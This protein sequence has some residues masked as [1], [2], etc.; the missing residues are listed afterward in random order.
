VTDFAEQAKESFTRSREH[1]SDLDNQICALAWAS[2]CKQN[3]VELR[4]EVMDRLL[5]LRLSL[6][7]MDA[8]V[9]LVEAGA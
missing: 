7:D 2:F 9:R 3:T 8:F 4:R 6:G 5:D 1:P